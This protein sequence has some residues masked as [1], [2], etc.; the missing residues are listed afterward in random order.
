MLTG[1]FKVYY[2][3]ILEDIR[4]ARLQREVQL[5][6]FSRIETDD[7]KKLY[8]EQAIQMG[9]VPKQKTIGDVKKEKALD[10]QR[11]KMEEVVA[12]EMVDAGKIDQKQK[13][14]E[15]VETAKPLT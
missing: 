12:Q 13:E 14:L 2:A 15:A 11:L 8:S 5:E 4:E 10:I 9:I 6:A 7:N 1:P 3:R